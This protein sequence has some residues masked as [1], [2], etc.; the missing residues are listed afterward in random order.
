MLKPGFFGWLIDHR[1]QVAVAGLLLCAVSLHLG[2]GVRTDYAVE[3]FFPVWDPER[4]T[5]ERYKSVFPK[6]DAQ[7][8]F[9]FKVKDERPPGIELVSTRC[10]GS[11]TSRSRTA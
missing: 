4:V 8:S 11:A 5:Y 2:R 3:Q 1:V 10:A 7:F 6:E 9:Y